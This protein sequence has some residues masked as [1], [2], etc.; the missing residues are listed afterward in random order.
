[1]KHLQRFNEELR[2]PVSGIKG[3]VSKSKISK[4]IYLA[5]PDVFRK[6][7]ISRLNSLKRFATKYGHEGIAPLDNIIPIED[8]L[9]NTQAH[10]KLIFEA[11]VQ[12]IKDC[13]III[14]N[15]EPFRGPS[16]DDGTAWEIGY[17]FALNKTIYGYSEF[18][19]MSLKDITDM[20]FDLSKQKKYPEY[21]I[22]GNPVNLMIA[23]SIK[24]SGGKIFKT[25]EMC[26]MDLNKSLG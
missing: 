6:N 1:M 4:K 12:L 20:M 25:F 17:G 16:I 9:K 14:A 24:G 26:L 19:D 7:A 22:M 23:D 2:I 3:E 18:S 8:E 15:L 10:S 11:N 21:E 13:D 5:G